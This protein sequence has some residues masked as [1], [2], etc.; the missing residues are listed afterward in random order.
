MQVF[1]VLNNNN[2]CKRKSLWSRRALACGEADCTS[3]DVAQ[4]SRGSK[5]I[6]ETLAFAPETVTT[7]D[8]FG[9]TDF[10]HT[11]GIECPGKHLAL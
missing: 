3:G 4:Q 10:F 6:D 1:R 11:G 5:D 7:D 9:T 8:A 2:N